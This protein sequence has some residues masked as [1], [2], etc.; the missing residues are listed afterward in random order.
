MLRDSPSTRPLLHHRPFVLFWFSRVFSAIAF[1]VSAVAVG[2]Q[3]YA[4]TGSA[5]SLGMVGLVQFL[6][7]VVLT[8]IVGHIADR[9]NRRT[10]VGTCQAIEGGAAVLLAVGSFAGWLHP[11]GIFAAVAVIGAARSFEHP[12]MSALLAGLIPAPLLP[13]AAALASSAHQ[14]ATIIGP[15]LGGLLYAAGPTV[16]YAVAASL[17]LS[18]SVLSALI[19]VERASASPEPLTFSSLFSGI[20][21][22]RSRPAILGA[23]SLDLFAVLLGGATA[24]LPI[25]ARD[26]LQTGPW[27]LGMLRSAPAVGALCMSFVLA[28]RPLERRIGPIM[29]AAVSVFGLATMIFAVST[30][31]VLSLAA[32][33]IL[34]GADV[35]SVVIRMTLVQ[36]ATP[37]GMRGRVSAINSLFIGTS[38]QFGEFESGVTA[39]LFGSV[40][41]VMIGGI[42]T[43]AVALIWMRWFPELRRI[44]NFEAIEA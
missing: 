11:A 31:L 4:L 25:Y 32:L 19:R 38:N 6:P 15:A 33:C 16:P 40:P 12:T 13:K 43:I 26:I 3:I 14:T 10:I 9:Y 27:G 34:G 2:W 44:D 37:D 7:M 5:F 8:F 17:F 22:I 41:A 39:A 29:F 18:A 36:L 28:R 42:G 35:I 21:F 24:L 23:I 20:A 30:S 1:Q